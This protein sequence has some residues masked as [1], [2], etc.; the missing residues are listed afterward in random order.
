MAE[1]APVHY[2][3]I[4]NTEAPEGQDVH[5]DSIEQ[6]KQL[7]IN[8]D[9]TFLGDVATGFNVATH[10]RYI[11]S[12]VTISVASSMAIKGCL[13]NTDASSN[14]VIHDHVA[15]DRQPGAINV[16]VVDQNGCTN[17]KNTYEG[18]DANAGW[19]ALNTDPILDRLSFARDW[20]TIVRTTIHEVGHD[21]GLVHGGT[22]TCTDAVHMQ[23]CTVAT[24]SDPNTIMGYT[25]DRNAA[26]YTAGELFT[27][28]LLQ[29]REVNHAVLNGTYELA[30]TDTNVED[31]TKMITFTGSDGRPIYISWEHDTTAASDVECDVQTP[32]NK[33]D[34]RVY[35]I[36]SMT[37]DGTETNFVCLTATERDLMHSL[38]VRVDE[39]ATAT[40]KD[41][42]RA[43]VV[44]PNRVPDI[45][46]QILTSGEVTAGAVVYEDAGIT[47]TY[48]GVQDQNALVQVTRK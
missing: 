22:E 19:A 2:I 18:I 3:Y 46:G 16:I 38:Q 34:P 7:L 30:G 13:D 24:T 20:K 37:I 40:R 41:P 43:L 42:S 36:G 44:R 23:D 14:R 48:V 35:R 8:S 25:I 10:H 39:P 45:T 27:L 29:P 31:T 6:D 12:A 47:V 15:A 33:K 1:N 17:G 4:P 9:P 11:P 26:D 32:Q 5:A 21:G 28:G